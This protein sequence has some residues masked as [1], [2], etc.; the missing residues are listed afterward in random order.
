MIKNQVYRFI[1]SRV[2]VTMPNLLVCPCDV[3]CLALQ[4]Q[5]VFEYVN[6]LDAPSLLPNFQFESLELSASTS[7]TKLSM[8][9]HP[10]L[11]LKPLPNH[12][13]ILMI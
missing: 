10:T 7:P 8:E 6:Y 5:E 12:L 1:K 9:E 4:C 11:E 13:R 3:I 2:G